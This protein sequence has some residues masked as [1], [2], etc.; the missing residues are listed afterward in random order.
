MRRSQLL[1]FIRAEHAGEAGI[2]YCLSRKKVEE[3]ADVPERPGHRRACRTTPA[4]TRDAR[5]R[6]QARFLRED[7]IVM[8]ATIAFGMGIDKPDVRFVAH[9][10]LPKSIEGYYQETGRAGRDGL[11]ADAWMAYG[12]QDVV[13]QRRMIDESEADEALQARA[14]GEA[15]RHARPVRDRRAAAACACSTISARPPRP[16]ATATPASTRRRPS[17]A[18]CAAQKLLSC[19]LPHRPALRRRHVIDVLRGEATEKVAQWRPRQ[20][21]APSASARE[22]SEP[23]MARD[24]AAVHRARPA[25][26]RPRRLRRAAAGGESRAVLKGE[27]SVALRAWREPKRSSAQSRG[28]AWKRSPGRRRRCSSGCAPGAS[29]PRAATACRPTSSS[30]TPR[31]GKSRARGPPSLDALRGISGIGAKKLEAYGEDIVGLV[32][33]G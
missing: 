26:G 11:P 7:G 9:L 5:R 28:A 18:R 14:G 22:R 19:D 29:R 8:V 31:C 13:Q 24:R 32:R 27:R 10:D 33:G 25:R 17:T 12:L 3:T 21:A 1:D 6:N 2:V 20:A 30:T 15:R 23:R 16:A 4:W